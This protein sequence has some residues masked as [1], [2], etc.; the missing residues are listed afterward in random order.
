MR[1]QVHVV[2]LEENEFT[3]PALLDCDQANTSC[4]VREQEPRSFGVPSTPV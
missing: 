3:N 1:F 4:Q 2:H